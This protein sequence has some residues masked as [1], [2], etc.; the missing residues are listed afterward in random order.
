M[1][2]A[3]SAKSKGKMLQNCGLLRIY[4]LQN[5]SR[6]ETGHKMAENER[7]KNLGAA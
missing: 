6:I 7:K 3:A 4:E 2:W 5:P 1:F